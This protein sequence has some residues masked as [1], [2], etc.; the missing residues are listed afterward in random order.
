MSS[1]AADESCGSLQGREDLAGNVTFE[2]THDFEFAHSL[3]GS[4]AQ[5]FFGSMVATKSDYDDA[6]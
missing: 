4:A 2:A 3:P 5:V 1:R 6:V